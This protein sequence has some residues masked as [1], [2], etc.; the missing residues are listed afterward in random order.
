MRDAMRERGRVSERH[1]MRDREG[2]PIALSWQNGRLLNADMYKEPNWESGGVQ[3][4]CDGGTALL[5]P[6]NFVN[7]LSLKLLIPNR[8]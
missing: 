1:S 4:R 6:S 5:I 3:W 2:V 7:Y 8:I